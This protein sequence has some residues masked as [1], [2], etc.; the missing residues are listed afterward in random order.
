MVTV[1]CALKRDSCLLHLGLLLLHL[2][3]LPES[4]GNMK[5]VC[6]EMEKTNQYD[7]GRESWAEGE[8]S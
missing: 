6:S 5:L 8:R 4:P 3:D 1:S 7:W 2:V